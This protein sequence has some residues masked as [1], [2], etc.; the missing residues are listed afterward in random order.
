MTK[1]NSL[2]VDLKNKNKTTNHRQYSGTSE[3]NVENHYPQQY[4]DQ[5]SFQSI[6]DN[7]TDWFYF[8]IRRY[9]T[10]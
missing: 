9:W 8:L 4:V 6:R 7:L 10:L 3:I 1:S 5:F 2:D